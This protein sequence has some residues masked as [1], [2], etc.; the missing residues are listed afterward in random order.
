MSSK[1]LCAIHVFIATLLILALLWDQ[2]GN[3]VDIVTGALLIALNVSLAVYDA[4]KT[5]ENK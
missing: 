3:K 1:S 4:L 2:G 5:L